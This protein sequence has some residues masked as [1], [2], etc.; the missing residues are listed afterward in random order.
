M[1][2]E[3]LIM[4]CCSDI[5]GQVRGKA[6]LDR[7]F[8]QRCTSGIGWC[9]TNIQISAFDQ[10][11]ETPFGALG[12]L[13]L[14]PDQ[15]ARVDVDFGPD[16]PGEH[17]V[18]CD[19]TH[20]DGRP[21]ACCVRTALKDALAALEAE[22]GLVLIAAFEH[23]FHYTGDAGEAGGA[24]ALRSMRRGAVL[25]ETLVAS[26]DQAGIE[27]DLFHPEYGA[28]QYEVTVAP[29]Q[30]LIAAD[31]A[32]IVRELAR[33][34]A[35]RL[36]QRVSF[37]PIVAGMAVGNGVH[38]HMS[39]LDVDR[40]PVLYA[41]DGPAGLSAQGGSFVAGIV[42]HLPA[43]VALTAASTVSY[44]RLVPHR[45]SAAFNN[46]GLRDR[47]A[48]M[49]IC[50][51]REDDDVARSYNVEYRAADAAASPYLLLA[52]LV[53]AGLQG[54]REGLPT[55]EPTQEDLALC[56]EAELAARGLRRLPTSL[57]QALDTFEADAVAKGWWPPQLLDVYL[58][59]KRGE[60]TLLEG[61]SGEEQAERYAEV[62]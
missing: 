9:P 30:G 10:I 3:P 53:R 29:T 56:T 1:R 31:Q 40:E 58:K 7:D 5:A 38:V 35:G 11:M 36:G 37:A 15:G 2:R 49:R 4:A 51:G 61:L 21:W 13:L 34:V 24:Y 20:T 54:L 47:E 14:K 41:A 46:L 33:S 42:R 52:A 39:L 26:L 44:Q 16:D 23:E 59:H 6:F 12:D 50:P 17:F 25:G 18:L 55:P 43:L 19:I 48:A 57:A 28:A 27:V 8:D 22:Y 45:W 60:V 62:Y 32:V